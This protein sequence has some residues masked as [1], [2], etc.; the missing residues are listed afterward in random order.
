VSTYPKDLSWTHSSEP[1]QITTDEVIDY[2]YFSDEQLLAERD[3]QR[4]QLDELIV[5]SGRSDVVDHLR[6]SI[7]REVERMS[8]ELRA[9][10]RSR[11]PSSR[12]LTERL[13]PIRSLTWPPHAD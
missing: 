11:H 7:E 1:L 6:A 8:G 12:S 13:R 2:T 10:A 4:T 5:H 9:R 3:R